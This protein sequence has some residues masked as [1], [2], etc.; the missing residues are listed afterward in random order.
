[1]GKFI[2]VRTIYIELTQYQLDGMS[3]LIE[4][5]VALA[6]AGTPGMLIAQICGS[7]MRVGVVGPNAT[8]SIQIAMGVTPGTLLDGTN[9][10][11]EA[12]QGKTP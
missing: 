2:V 5:I 6:E 3:S 8:H 1:M 12:S 10:L 11:E 7:D 4:E 9:Y